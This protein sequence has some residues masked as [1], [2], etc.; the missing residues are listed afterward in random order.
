[1]LWNACGKYRLSQSASLISQARYVISHDTG[2]MHISAAFQKPIVSIWGSTVLDL[3]M[4][5]YRTKFIALENKKLWCRPCSKIGYSSCPLGHFKCMKELSFNTPIHR[6]LPVL[7]P[8]PS[9]ASS[10]SGTSATGT[11]KACIATNPCYRSIHQ[12]VCAHPFLLQKFYCPQEY[13][14]AYQIDNPPTHGQ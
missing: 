11:L 2:L 12:D 5:P 7:S 6:L 9:P 4:Y 1:M 10:I 8:P 14:Q 3:G 13:Y